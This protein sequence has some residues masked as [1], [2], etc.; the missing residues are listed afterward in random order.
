MDKLDR[1]QRVVGAHREVIADRNKRQVYSLLPD[2]FHIAEETCILRHIDFLTLLRRQ[3]KAA[4]IAATRAIGQFRAVQGKRQF[5][6]A[7][8]IFEPAADML[9]MCLDPFV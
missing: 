1:T 6:I 4:R 9:S 8:W 7:K 5:E 2:Q 3:Q